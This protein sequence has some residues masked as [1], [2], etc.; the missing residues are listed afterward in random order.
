[1]RNRP[2]AEI[3]A[4]EY[5][6]LAYDSALRTA[7]RKSLNDRCMWNPPELMRSNTIGLAEWA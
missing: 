5:P 3:M 6:A 2:V 4:T 7:W 1:M